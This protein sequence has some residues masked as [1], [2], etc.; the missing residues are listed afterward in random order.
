MLG[1]LKNSQEGSSQRK[2][3]DLP[4]GTCQ[5]THSPSPKKTSAG[6]LQQWLRKEGEPPAK[7]HKA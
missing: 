3:N 1:W 2:E 6:I 4:K 7:K 5:F